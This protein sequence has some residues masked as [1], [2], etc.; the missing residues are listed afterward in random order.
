MSSDGNGAAVSLRRVRKVYDRDPASL[1]WRSLLPAIQERP[2]VPLV[3]LDG[4][5]LEVERGSAVG[6]IGPNGAGKSTVLRLLAGVTSPTAGSVDVRGSVGSLIELGLGFHPELTGRENARCSLVMRGHSLGDVD[7]SLDGIVEFAGI[8]AAFDTPVKHYSAGMRA[9]L[10][11]AVATAERSD[12]LA[13]DEVLA[14]GDR[15]FQDRCVERIRS[16][17]A[18]GTALVFV[19]HDMML[20]S[21]VCDRVVHLRHGRVVDDGPASA[22][23]E[24]YLSTSSV[25]YRQPA[26]PPMRFEEVAVSSSL[27]PWDP[28][29][30]RA[31]VEVRRAIESPVVGADLT[32]PVVDPG[33]VLASSQQVVPALAVPGRYV[34][35]GRSSRVS[36][37]SGAFRMTFSLIDGAR[38][39]RSDQ[40]PA[41]LILP[42]GR[43]G[44]RPGLA[45]E[46][47]WRCYPAPQGTSPSPSER[48]AP[49]PSGSPL[50]AVHGVTKRFRSGR[51]RG[52][53]ALGAIPGRLGEG[54]RADVTALDDVS[55]EVRP[56]EAVGIIGSNG[57]GKST[58]LRI[59]AGLTAPDRGE[60]SI[61]GRVLPLLDASVGLHPELTGRENVWMLGRLLG[62][63]SGHLRRRWSSIEELAGIDA[64]IDAPVRQYSTGMRAR[65]GFAIAMQSDAEVLLVD[66]LL[67][68]GDEAFRER[69]IAQV[70]ARRLAGAAVL[71]VSHELLMVEEVC[72]RVVRLEH[73]RVVDDGLAAD[74]ID[75]YGGHAWARGTQDATSGIRLYPIEVAQ[76][77]IAIG[78]RLELS[79]LVAVEEPSA[80]ASLEISYRAVPEDRHAVRTAED[81]RNITMYSRVV[82]PPGGA[83]ARG[84]WHR[85]ELEVDDNEFVGEIDVVVAAVEEDAILAETWQRV[86][87][88]SPRP[89]G[90]P[91]L[92]LRFDWTATK[93]PAERRPAVGGDPQPA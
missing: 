49:E 1:R 10:A 51:S 93:I 76:R 89:E 90:F 47:T 40:H 28:I 87:V 22:V 4:L 64:A 8:G 23:V 44:G 80:T 72:S 67:S 83:L 57:A 11:F 6:I 75:A 71:F 21:H 24:R 30:V 84:G 2:R 58:L 7:G 34:L 13:V 53:H 48:R 18:A 63:S 74:V 85:Y 31:E 60:V 14:V 56:G 9:R 55:L 5:D 77:H 39:E 46:P 78:G 25:G 35:E 91:S 19:S 86:V 88:G 16:M 61:A 52:A 73:G 45:V 36:I 66:E 20:V 82:E 32:L 65:L 33:L 62:M 59:V 43:V 26:D 12:V 38:R 50:V 15:D 79:G 3:A 92:H 29:E 41:D 42:G 81:R 37:D 27:Q 69:A 68:V 70:Q 17:V 54:G